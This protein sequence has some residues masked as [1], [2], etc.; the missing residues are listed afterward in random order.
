MYYLSMVRNIVSN[1]DSH[2][3]LINLM[4]HLA[5]SGVSHGFYMTKEIS[6]V[7][8]QLHIHAII[9][10]DSLEAKVN[11]ICYI[12]KHHLKAYIDK[13]NEIASVYETQYYLKYIRKD[14]TEESVSPDDYYYKDFS[15]TTWDNLLN[16]KRSK[17][18]IE[19]DDPFIDSEDELI[20]MNY[21]KNTI[22]NI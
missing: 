15:K 10:L 6:T 20:N 16:Y 5:K 13:V 17:V 11:M 21:V 12:N 1:I 4:K 7:N 9:A 22:E 18:I 8:K 3:H 19:V 2:R 14:L